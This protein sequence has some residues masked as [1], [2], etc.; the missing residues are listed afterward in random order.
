MASE[1]LPERIRPDSIGDANRCERV[2]RARGEDR[3]TE[4]PDARPH[5]L[6]QDRMAAPDAT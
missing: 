3:E 5:R 4:R 6:G 2:A 1:R